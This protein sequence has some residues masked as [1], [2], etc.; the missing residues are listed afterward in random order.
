MSTTCEKPVG[1]GYPPS[2]TDQ[3]RP[4]DR[5]VAAILMIA[6][7][8]VYLLTFDKDIRSD[9]RFYFW[10]ARS[11]ALRGSLDV[12]QEIVAY[13]D[14]LDDGRL[15]KRA[16]DRTYTQ[17]GIGYSLVLTPVVWLALCVSRIVPLGA[18]LQMQVSACASL[19]SVVSA[20]TVALL[21]LLLRREERCRSVA[22]STSL[23]YAFATMAWPY[24]TC[25][26]SEPVAA[27]CVVGATYCLSRAEAGGSLRW[28]VLAGLAVGYTVVV[29]VFHV[30]LFPCFLG[31]AVYRARRMREGL[32]W[33]WVAFLGSF[34]A[35]F[36]ACCGLVAL[37][38]WHQYGSP[39]DPGYLPT[40]HPFSIAEM[41]DGLYGLILSTGTGLLI[42]NA[43]LAF[44]VY[45]LRVRKLSGMDRFA[46]W[47]SAS[48]CVPLSAFVKWDGSGAWGPR[49]L[50]VVLP[51]LMVPL[52][53]VVQ[54]CLPP[55]KLAFTGVCAGSLLIQLPNVVMSPGFGTWV[56]VMRA[57]DI[58]AEA[59][60]FIPRF[61]PIWIEWASVASFVRR[62]ILGEE[63]L[64]LGYRTLSWTDLPSE[65]GRL[66]LVRPESPGACELAASPT[67]WWYRIL[68]GTVIARE[69]RS[70]LLC[71]VTFLAGGTLCVIAASGMGWLA[72]RVLT[73]G[74]SEGSR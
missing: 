31:Y 48:Y 64:A 51:L 20:L 11:L 46:L 16:P 7:G 62:E 19:N 44:L 71:M 55:R 24:A 52:S 67:V 73:G 61:S 1:E 9:G 34:L 40:A 69:G 43:P 10:T 8:S 36:G 59:A 63:S 33:S 6:V 4:S 5:K 60:F 39:I 65:R 57:T 41:P 54:E 42:F 58:P 45:L 25:T 49:F 35:S 66:H 56:S 26:M 28:P 2:R 14:F 74:E 37:A 29:K 3:H 68:K 12:S 47:L 18:D 17:Y 38:S 15:R 27:L 70:S 32:G 50:L 21:F 30:V 22:A 53:R 72:R 23:C 13:P